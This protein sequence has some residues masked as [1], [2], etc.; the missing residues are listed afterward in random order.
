MIVGA[1]DF[2][3]EPE[4]VADAA[5]DVPFTEAETVIEAAATQDEL[6]VT[7]KKGKKDKESVAAST[8]APRLY[9]LDNVRCC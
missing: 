7:T 8:E 2:V 4:Q 3:A 5:A 1:N 9:N 6:P